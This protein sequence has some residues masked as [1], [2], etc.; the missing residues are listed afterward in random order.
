ML[1]GVCLWNALILMQFFVLS[2]VSAQVLEE[3]QS[4]EQVQDLR[5]EFREIHPGLN[6]QAVEGFK[7]SVIILAS[8]LFLCLAGLLVGL[9]LYSR[10]KDSETGKATVVKRGKNFVPWKP[11][12]DS[13]TTR[14][15]IDE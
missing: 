3:Q 12:G 6:R 7:T 15:N 11:G 4:E 9:A 10:S 14:Y 8:I 5:E 2:E 13:P 1:K